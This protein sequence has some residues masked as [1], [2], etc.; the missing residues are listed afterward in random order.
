MCL[1]WILCWTKS[2]ETCLYNVRLTMKVQYFV[3][4]VC[5]YYGNFEKVDTFHLELYLFSFFPAHPWL[6]QI[7]NRLSHSGAPW[8]N[9]LLTRDQH[10][11]FW[12]NFHGLSQLSQIT[13]ERCDLKINTTRLTFRYSGSEGLQSRRGICNF[14]KTSPGDSDMGSLTLSPTT[15]LAFWEPPVQIIHSSQRTSMFPNITYLMY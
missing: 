6:K 15:K 14:L 9:Q 8:L 1:F 2:Q 13:V 4:W 7:L 12:G 3:L 5:Y 11:P 10:M